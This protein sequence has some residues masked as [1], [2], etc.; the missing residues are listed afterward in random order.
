MS[1]SILSPVG[2]GGGMGGGTAC[3]NMI[4]S[5]LFSVIDRVKL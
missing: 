5:L 1:F 2:G 3:K 4:I